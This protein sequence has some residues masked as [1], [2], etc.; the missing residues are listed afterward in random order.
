MA[1]PGAAGLVKEPVIEEGNGP[2]LLKAGGWKP[3]EKGFDRD[4]GA[5]VCDNGSDTAALGGIVQTVVLNQSEPMPIAAS[6]DSRAEGVSGSRDGDYSIYLDIIYNDGTPQW[7]V[8]APFAPETHG[9]ET[10]SLVFR[11][12]KPIKEVNYHLLLRRRS[13]KAM[14]REA[15]LAELRLPSRAGWFDGIPVAPRGTA[16][17]YQV[18][19]VGSGSGIHAFESGKAL[20]LKLDARESTS[21]TATFHEGRLTDLTGKERA[22][23]LYFT[24]SVP[25]TGAVWLS[26]PRRSE[27]VSP[28]REYIDSV[29]YDAGSAGQLSRWPFAA[30]SDGKI[31]TAIALDMAFPAFFRVGYSAGCRELYIAYDLG[32]APERNF[33]DFRFCV[34][35]FN[36][37]WGFRAALAEYYRLF[38]AAFERRIGRQGLWMPFQAISSVKGWEDFGFRFKEGNDETAWDDAHDMLT[39]RYTEPQTWWMSMPK[40]MPRTMDAAI[41]EANRLAAEG[42]WSAKALLTSGYRDEHGRLTARLLDTPWTDGAVWS[43]NSSPAVKGETTDFRNKWNPDLREKLYGTGHKGDQDGEYIDSAECYVTT[44][45]DFRRDHFAGSPTPLVYSLGGGRR[46]ALF[47][48]LVVADYVHAIAD[49]IHGMGKFMM[50][51]STP[52]SVCWLAPW[53]DVMGT[54]WD[55]NPDGVWRPMSDADLLYRRSLC[56][57]KPYCFL[58]NSD[59]DR[60]PYAKVEKYMKRCLAYGMFPGFFSA[61]AS[62]GHYFSR[63][64]LYDRDRPLF[65]KYMPLIKLVAEAGWRPITGA[66][67]SDPAVY[68]ERF[69]DRYLTVFNDGEA[70]KAAVITVSGAAPRGARELVAGRSLAVSESVIRLDLDPEDVAV[71]ELDTP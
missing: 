23:T 57:T 47:K 10:E 71:I 38:P 31:G 41:G 25:D 32:L 2:N 26:D 58:Q 3:Y 60:F 24:V 21:G 12:S 27:P 55:W 29:R 13:G 22:V 52:D 15:K 45:L 49:D 18:R 28:G 68:V 64:D 39:F 67:S 30:V 48:E 14:F 70:R 9:W 20:G 46:P 17:G 37:A 69:G 5:F 65:R 44:T 19:D 1:E 40:G 7:G 43:M 54:E 66:R 35:Q 11:P 59:F 61:N 6:A 34:Y 63:P 51:N 8:I 42:D 36:P 50:A 16:P 56:G 53:L 33:A 62:E 4:G